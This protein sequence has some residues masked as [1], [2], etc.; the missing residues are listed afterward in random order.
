MLDILDFTSNYCLT[1]KFRVKEIKIRNIY[2]LKC[3]F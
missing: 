3:S 2:G 1:I